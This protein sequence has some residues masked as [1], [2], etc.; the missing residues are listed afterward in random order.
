MPQFRHRQLVVTAHQWR[1]GG[2]PVPGVRT[3]WDDPAGPPFV[4]GRRGDC[5]VYEG[6]WVIADDDGIHHNVVSADRFAHFYEP[7]TP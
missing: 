5:P 1:R 2:P 4:Q 6:D 3:H 7:V